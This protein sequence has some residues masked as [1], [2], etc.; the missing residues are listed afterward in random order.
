MPAWRAIGGVIAVSFFNLNVA[1]CRSPS[2]DGGREPDQ[3]QQSKVVDLPGIDTSSLT[4][5]EKKEW[6]GY[7]SELLAPCADQPVNIAQCVKESRACNLCGPAAEFL[8]EQVR[9]GRTRTQVETA[10]NL[11]FSADAVKSIDTTGAP[12]MGAK[13]PTVLIV[14][15]ADFECPFCRAAYPVLDEAV[16]RYPDQIRLVYKNYPLSSHEHSEE[17]ARAGVAA[18]RQD[19]FWPMHHAMF[20]HQEDGLSR[21][22]LDKLAR[23]VGLDMKKYT[24]DIESE[25]VADVVSK[26]RREAEKLGLK[27]T[28]MIYINGRHFEIEL[29]NLLEDLD[30][31]LQLEIE[32]KTGKKPQPKPVESARDVAGS[33]A[34]P[35]ASTKPPSPKENPKEAPKP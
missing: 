9:R 3:S 18:A 20:E 24:E 34:A 17:A 29:F 30:P 22:T 10:Y 4:P 25:G 15:W 19:K 5:R 35:A 31:W 12:A 14:E 26:D 8:V 6:S 16:Q 33:S 27:G 7:V 32:Q 1:T 28:P 13:D 21:K 23:D 11:R 2:G